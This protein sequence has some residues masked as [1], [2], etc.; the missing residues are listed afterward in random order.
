[1]EVN[2]FLKW[3]T[4]KKKLLTG[5][6]QF[7]TSG[8][9]MELGT[10]VWSH[11]SSGNKLFAPLI[12]QHQS[13]WGLKGPYLSVRTQEIT[14]CRLVNLYN[15]LLRLCNNHGTDGAFHDTPKVE[16]SKFPANCVF[17]NTPLNSKFQDKEGRRSS[18][19]SSSQFNMADPFTDTEWQLCITPSSG[20]LVCFCTI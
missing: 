9:Q 18:T 6:K 17:R 4:G 16:F 19:A 11:Y 20:H 12:G 2:L 5:F 1:M 8:L 13:L 7:L 15:S 3:N 10:A 14:T